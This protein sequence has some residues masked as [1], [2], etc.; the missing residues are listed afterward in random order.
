MILAGR[1]NCDG[2]I[3]RRKNIK[4]TQHWS[5]VPARLTDDAGARIAVNEHLAQRENRVVHRDVEKLALP[6]PP[7]RMNRRHHAKRRERA[8]I[9]VTDAWTGFV[10]GTAFRTRDRDQP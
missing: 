10:P 7:R 3:A 8:G 5:A 4:R 6:C 2:T 9:D 1:R